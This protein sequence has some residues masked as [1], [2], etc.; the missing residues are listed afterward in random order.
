MEY[1]SNGKNIARF[2]GRGD[3]KGRRGSANGM[4]E[5]WN[6]GQE[7]EK[8]LILIPLLH[9][10]IIPIGISALGVFAVKSLF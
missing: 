10:S 5:Y 8:N 7:L 4:L 3:R 9:H 6:V 2:T 1:W